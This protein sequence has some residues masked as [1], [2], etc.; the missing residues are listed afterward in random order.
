[1][2]VLHHSA[3]VANDDDHQWSS[4]VTAKFPSRTGISSH[5]SHGRLKS[6]APV[7]G[8]GL[9]KIDTGI[10]SSTQIAVAASKA[11]KRL[12][13]WHLESD[14]DLDCNCF[15]CLAR[16][17]CSCC[18]CLILWASHL[19]KVNGLFFIQIFSPF[20]LFLFFLMFVVA[21]QV[22]CIVSR[23]C[24]LSRIKGVG[25]LNP[26]SWTLKDRGLVFG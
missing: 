7:S 16:S 14:L 25:R 20:S 2:I 3:K 5:H 18:S 1:M 15:S 9:P 26:P 13:R 22:A 23:F 24:R 6:S 8:K 11:G 19:G 12:V 17:F 4:L 21:L 10:A